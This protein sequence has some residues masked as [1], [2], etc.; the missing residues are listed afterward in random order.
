MQKKVLTLPMA[1]K[2]STVLLPSLDFEHSIES[3]TCNEVSPF[4]GVG[5]N[6]NKQNL[7]NHLQ[8]VYAQVQHQRLQPMPLPHT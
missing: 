1:E 6:K 8:A 4:M 3:N 7:Y 2:T 5:L